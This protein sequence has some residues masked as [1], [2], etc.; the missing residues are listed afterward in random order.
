MAITSNT[1]TGNGSNKLFSITFPY[2]ET[3]DIDVYLN[4]VLQ[5]VTTQYTFANATTVEF[6]AAPGAGTTVLL[7]RS[8]DDTTLQATFFPGSSIKAADLND[9]FDQVL[10]LAQ[11]TNNNVA[12][13][14]AGQIPAGTI[15]DLQ[16]NAAANINATKLSFT[17]AGTGATARTVDSKLKDVVSVKDF[18][19]VGNGVAND[20]AA[21]AAAFTHLNAG[22]TPKSL[23][24]PAGNYVVDHS[25]C[26]I[27]TSSRTV[28]G[29]GATSNIIIPNRSSSAFGIRVIGTSD[30]VHVSN[31]TIDAISVTASGWTGANGE[32]GI[33][34][35]RADYCSV[36]NCTVNGASIGNAWEVGIVCADTNNTVVSNNIVNKTAGNG[37]SLDLLLGSENTKGN[38]VIGNT[39][40]NIGDSGVAFHNNVRY[41]SAIGNIINNPTATGIDVAGCNCCLFEGNVVSNSAQYGIRLLQNLSYRTVDNTVTGN[42]VYHPPNAGAFAAITINNVERNTITNNRLLGNSTSLTERGIFVDYSSTGTTTHPITAETLYKLRGMVISG[43]HVERFQ[44]GIGFDSGGGITGATITVDKNSISLCTTGLQYSTASSE[45]RFT[46]YGQN[47]FFSCTNNISGTGIVQIVYNTGIGQ[48]DVT[49]DVT[50]N[51]VRV[52]RGVGEEITNTVVGN[53]PLRSRTTGS[54]NTGIGKDSLYAVT[55]G[56]G[57]TCVGV[58]TAYAL[59][60][61][62]YNTGIGQNALAELTS[63]SGNI[64]IGPNNNGGSYLPVFNVTTQNDRVAIG[65]TSTSNAYVQVAWTV[66]SD[67]R[68]KINFAPVPHGLDFVNQLKP[69]SFQFKIDRDIEQP[70]GPIRYGFKA[71]EIL[72][73]EGGTGI[74]IDAE[75]PEKLRYNGEALVPVL[76]NAIQELSKEIGALKVQLSS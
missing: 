6:V 65:S 40:N 1:Y 76:V 71:Q 22:S 51:N 58:G 24:I 17:Q 61:G 39:L 69:T 55:T 29:E 46:V 23:F 21:F 37:I 12:N 34:I 38:V 14:V 70:N 2:L 20:T 45:V 47:W 43:N 9:N 16:V 31:V 49:G 19:A 18:G 3:T 57:N 72:E 25:T 64:A 53:G 59:V 27:T 54:N 30:S 62:S 52:G 41:S 35:L 68:D 11:E 75:D 33:S 56:S 63:G 8:S 50:A 60:G 42:T 67:A 44:N 4:G 7:N 15:T 66:V 5:T 28:F 10:Y 48:L 13:A 36:T 73:L 26:L 74:I 32:A